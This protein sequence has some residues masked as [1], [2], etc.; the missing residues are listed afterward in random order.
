MNSKLLAIVVCGMLLTA[1]TK[2]LEEINKNPNAAQEVSAPQLILPAVIKNAAKSHFYASMTRGNIIADYYANQYVSGFD[3]AWASSQVDDYFLWT[4]YDKLRDVENLLSLSRTKG[5]K[6]NEG[7][8]LILK[9]WMFQTLTDIYGDIPF[10]EATK[11]KSD[12]NFAPAYDSQEDVYY[13]MLDMLKN[14]NVLLSEGQDPLNGDIMLQGKPMRWRQFANGLRLRMLLRISSKTGLKIDVSKEMSD[15][16]NDPLNNPLFTSFQDQAALTYLNEAGNEF[17]GYNDTPASDRHL[18]TTL[19][20]ILKEHNDPRIHYYAAPT[21]ASIAANTIA[22]AGVPN[23]ISSSEEATYNGGKNNQ[24]SLSLLLTPV[25]AFSNAS[26]T[27]SESLFMTYAEVQLILAEARERNLISTGN[28]ETYYLNGIKD[29][30][31]YLASR[32]PGNFDFPKSTDILP[33]ASFYTQPM[34]QYAG[35]TTEKLYKI[36][37]QKWL[38]LFNGGFEGW[39]EWRR[40][41]VPAGIKAGPNSAIKEIP[42]RSRYPLTEQRLNA[43]HYNEALQRQGPDDLLTR[44]WWNK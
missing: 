16:V 23:G 19:E 6:N 1:C 21:P 8:Q 40:T 5:L 15:I 12:G 43:T 31:N 9:A 29:H 7:V 20:T 3:N 10:S 30:F 27:A 22:Y 33:A 24:S 2:D 37:L 42:R 18:S 28:A 36:R 44:V 26:K 25:S 35:S 13:G 17:P 32:I 14:A 41:G 38:V 39:S 4:F 11:G 34:V